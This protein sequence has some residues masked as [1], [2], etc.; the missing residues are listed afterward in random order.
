MFVPGGEGAAPGPSRVLL[1]VLVLATGAGP[2][3][4][5]GLAAAGP[6]LID[7]LNISASTFGLL[8]TVLFA[9]AALTSIV[10]GRLADFLSIRAQMVLNFGGTALALIIAAIGP[11]FALMVAAMIVGGFSQVIANATTNRVI[12]EQ[13]PQHRRATWVGVKQS[14]VQVSQVIAGLMFP[15]LAVLVGWSGAAVV[16]SLM[17]V[18]VLFWSLRQL[19]NEQPTDWPNLRRVVLTSRRGAPGAALSRSVWAF[20]AIAFLSGAGTLATNVYLPIFAVDDLG[21][22]VV[23][24]G[25][26][27]GVAGLLGVISRIWW[28]AALGRGHSP[29]ALLTLIAAGG[30]VGALALAASSLVVNSILFWVGVVLH[31]L[32]VLGT[33]VVLNGGLMQSLAS[34]GR[35]GEAS[36]AITL[37]VYAGFTAGP[38]AMSVVIALTGS[39]AWVWGIVAAFYTVILAVTWHASR[40]TGLR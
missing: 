39:F 6:I 13:V 5:L 19:P 4:N 26:A 23:V 18:I 24:A 17:L 20:T 10:T 30:I 15:G 36:G 2:L 11:I 14:G 34:T 8:L 28:G 27:L 38:L 37:G 3:F 31:G 29:W 9:S 25:L 22:G 7:D 33:N 35:I 16:A 1:L 40:R 21:I 12:L 32:S